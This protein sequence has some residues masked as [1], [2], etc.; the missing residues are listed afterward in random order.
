MAT[1][2]TCLNGM[3][4]E[5]EGVLQAM[6]HRSRTY[7]LV[8]QKLSSQNALTDLTIA[9]IVS[10]AQYEH[11]QNQYQQGL[12]HVQGLRRIA[13]LQGGVLQ[14]LENNSSG[15]VQKVLRYGE[16]SMIACS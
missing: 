6:H 2:I 10:M 15:L 4:S 12:I 11:H 9:A 14:F 5:P 3:V 13:Q 7:R 8:N 1:A 16:R